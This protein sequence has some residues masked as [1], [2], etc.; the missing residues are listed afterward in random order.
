MSFFWAFFGSTWNGG[1]FV[2]S[3][4]FSRPEYPEEYIA[5]LV[6]MI[7]LYSPLIFLAYLLIDFFKRKFGCRKLMK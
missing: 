5:F 2:D 6:S 1:A 7:I 4:V 3:Y